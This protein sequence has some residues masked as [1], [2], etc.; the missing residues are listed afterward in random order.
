MKVGFGLKIDDI[1]DCYKFKDDVIVWEKQFWDI[2]VGPGFYLAPIDTTF[3]LYR[4]GPFIW[5]PQ[6]VEE[7]KLRSIRTGAPYIARHL[8]WYTDSNH[9]TE[10]HVFYRAHA[11]PG[12]TTWSL[13]AL[14]PNV[15]Q[16]VEF[17]RKGAR[18]IPLPRQPAN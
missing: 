12:I 17:A 3:A 16:D 9:P 13:D 15:A 18:M 8:D 1:P 14:P 11:V 5:T 6:L 10:E 4:G 2:P 7:S